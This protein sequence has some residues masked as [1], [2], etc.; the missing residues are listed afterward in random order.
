MTSIPASRSA[1]ATTLAPRSWPSSPG[2]A[3]TIR[4]GVEGVDPASDSTTQNYYRVI[5]R[6]AAECH[7][8]HSTCEPYASRDSGAAA[9]GVWTR[10]RS[11]LGHHTHGDVFARLV[12][13]ADACQQW[14]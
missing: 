9:R 2:F 3:T 14:A 6:N 10:G 5:F 1:R 4:S 13:C 12:V 11:R 8:R 7:W